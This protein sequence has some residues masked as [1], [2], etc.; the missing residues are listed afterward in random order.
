MCAA[1]FVGAVAPGSVA[2]RS[3]N[4]AELGSGAAPREHG[5]VEAI[6]CAKTAANAVARLALLGIEAR[7]TCA[8]AWALVAS[9]GA[10]IGNV[11]GVEALAAAADGFEAAQADALCALHQVG[12]GA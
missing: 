5:K 4:A 1:V 12:A 10:T 9:T 6:N 8:D 3:D 11:R 7:H 2:P